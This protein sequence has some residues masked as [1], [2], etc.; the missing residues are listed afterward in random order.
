MILLRRPRL[1]RKSRSVRYDYKP[2]DT[3]YLPSWSWHRQGNDANRT[4]KFMTIGCEPETS[5]IGLSVLEDAGK[6]P[7]ADLPPAPTS[8]AAGMGAD[9]YARRKRRLSEALA[10]QSYRTGRI[11]VAY[12]DLTLLVNPKGTRSTFMLDEFLGSKTSGLTV[13]M[14]QIAARQVS[15][16][17]TSPRRRGRM[18]VQRS[19]GAVTA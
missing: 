15:A 14:N 1:D 13:A 12:E 3:V 16:E 7:F 5:L 2:W 8:T 4:A 9:P 6:T 18:L 10:Q 19:R 11:H 17:E